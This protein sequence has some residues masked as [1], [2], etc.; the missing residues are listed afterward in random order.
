MFYVFCLID[1]CDHWESKFHCS[2]EEL[3]FIVNRGEVRCERHNKSVNWLL[4]VSEL[5]CTPQVRYTEHVSIFAT[6]IVPLL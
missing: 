6:I 1:I 4:Q 5:F 2:R 3:L